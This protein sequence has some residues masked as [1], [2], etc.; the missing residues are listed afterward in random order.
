MAKNSYVAEVTFKSLRK[1][2]NTNRFGKMFELLIVM[3][4]SLRACDLLNN[5]NI[6]FKILPISHWF[7]VMPVSKAP[8]IEC[9]PQLTTFKSGA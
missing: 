6:D 9:R 1:I 3:Y 5:L 4:K 8:W 7:E 2:S